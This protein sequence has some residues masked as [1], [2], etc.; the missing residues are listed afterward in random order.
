MFGIP[1]VAA[2]IG[3]PSGEMTFSGIIDEIRVVNTILDE[4]WL[5]AEANLLTLDLLSIGPEELTPY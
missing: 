2:Q 3:R 1:R 5:T 4:G